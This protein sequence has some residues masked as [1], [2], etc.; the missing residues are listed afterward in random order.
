MAN[1]SRPNGFRAV[2]QL[3]GAPYNGAVHWY[4]QPATDATPTFIGDIVKLTGAGSSDARSLGIPEVTTIT[5][6]GDV[7]VG[8]VVGIEPDPNNLGQRSRLAST[9]RYLLVADDPDAFFEVQD[10]GTTAAGD[11]GQNASPLIAAGSAVTGISA[12][13]LDGTTKNTTNTLMLK[14]DQMVQRADNEA[15]TNGKFIVKF[16][17]HQYANQTAGV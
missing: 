1:V 8:V 9:D 6:V 12:F 11:V 16:N 3:H 7:P 5:A 14:I 17:R 10:S 13:Q 2:G 15:N 4:H